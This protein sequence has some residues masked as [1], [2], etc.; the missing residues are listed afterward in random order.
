VITLKDVEQNVP[1]ARTWLKRYKF[2]D[3]RRLDNNAK[4]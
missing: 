3:V 2:Y 1:A 4:H